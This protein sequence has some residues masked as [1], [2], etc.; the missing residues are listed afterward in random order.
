MFGQKID[1]YMGVF[2]A[3]TLKN[4]TNIMKIH[5]IFLIVN[6]RVYSIKKYHFSAGIKNN[7]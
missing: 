7:M 6:A 3:V 4:T 5:N 2:D 1:F